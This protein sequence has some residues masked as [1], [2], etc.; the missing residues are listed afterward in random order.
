MRDY[1]KVYSKFWS[2]ENIQRL[3]DDGRMLALYLMTCQHN[4]ISGVFRLP[5]GY[6]TE[7]LNWSSERVSKGFS[8][9]FENGFCNRCETTKWVWVI[10]HFDWNPPEN[11]NQL[12]AAKKCAQQIPNECRWKS[13][14]MR[15]WGEYLG[16]DKAEIPEPL[17]N[18]SE[19]LS[20]P[21]A[22]A[23]AVAESVAVAGAVPF[24][25]PPLTV[26]KTI[27]DWQPKPETLEALT[28]AVYGVPAKFID[29]QLVEFRTY[30]R[31]RNETAS[32]WDA[33]FIQR[34]SGEWKGRG[35]VWQQSPDPPDGS[36]KPGWI[37]QFAEEMARELESKGNR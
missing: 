24:T 16:F 37:N 34:C 4:T 31:D 11:P 36:G 23:V 18:P 17:E 19:T 14:F 6:A 13:G 7:D 29:E 25:P 8:E 2:S 10:K 21:V 22:V 32:S 3:S 5:D 35:H 15:V 12:K 28:S 1:G 27:G 9:L 30:W 33:K 26:V 20:K